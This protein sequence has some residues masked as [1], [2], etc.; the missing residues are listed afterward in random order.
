MKLHVLTRKEE[1][2]D[3]RLPGKVVVVLD[4]LF[5]TTSIAAVLAAGA[6]EVVPALD[7][8]AARSVAAGRP[9]GSFVLAGELDAETLPGFANPT[10]L[11]LLQLPLRGRALV[12]STT[13]SFAVAL[14]SVIWPFA[15][16][17]TSS[18]W[19]DQK[20]PG[21]VPVIIS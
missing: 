5:A 4:V 10:P 9:P 11:A 2:D 17:S 18:S 19:M 20:R 3:Q 13:G 1:L 14:P 12:Y 16:E 7:G 15:S 8:D 6:S 21:M